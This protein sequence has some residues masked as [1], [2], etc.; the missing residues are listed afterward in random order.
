MTI[1]R[2][3]LLIVPLALALAPPAVGQT[4]GV[5]PTTGP[6]VNP[7]VQAVRTAP[8]PSAT[9]DAYA[10]GVAAGAVPV[11]DLEQAYVRRMLDLGAPELADSQAHNL[12]NRGAA[13]ATARG[14]AAIN[15]AI[16]G[17]AHGTIDNLKHGLAEWRDDVFLLRTAGQ[18]VAWS[19]LPK[20]RSTLTSEDVAGVEWLRAAGHSHQPFDEAYR[21]AS[22]AWQQQ[23]PLQQQQPQQQ[24]Q[25]STNT[26]QQSVSDGSYAAPSGSTSNNYYYY[27]SSGSY[28][29][30]GYSSYPYYGYGYGYYGGYGSYSINVR[31][32]G[33]YRDRQFILD[34]ARF[35]DRSRGWDGHAPGADRT[36][37]NGML[38]RDGGNFRNT[39]PPPPNAANSRALPD[40]SAL[41]RPTQGAPPPAGRPPQAQGPPQGP[42]PQAAPP[43]P[44]AAPPAPPRPPG[45]PPGPPHP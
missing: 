12:V 39:L 16:R 6:A 43:R 38:R 17:N 28:P 7:L 40:N 13:D 23:S 18:V 30:Y 45:P 34:R 5:A 37:G 36:M 29:Y 26:Q 19:D 20:N 8:D 25:A 9:I 1:Y 35:L 22:E 21:T 33:N 4:W 11:V 15:D 10:R 24:Q 3:V 41:G 32:D 14:V 44:P 31:E 42:R 2:H 27:P